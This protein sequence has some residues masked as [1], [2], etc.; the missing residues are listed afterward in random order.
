MSQ[1]HR[2]FTC[3]RTPF[4]L[5]ECKTHPQTPLAHRISRLRTVFEARNDA[6]GVSYKF[7]LPSPPPNSVCRRGCRRRSQRQWRWAPT[8]SLRL[9]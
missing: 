8:L 3:T 7:Y 2:H 9:F 5:S 6:W 1:T 4:V